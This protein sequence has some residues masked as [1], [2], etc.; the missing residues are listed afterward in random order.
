MAFDIQFTDSAGK[1]YDMSTGTWHV[2]T[3]Q[4]VYIPITSPY[5][6][7]VNF[8]EL[9]GDTFVFF[10]SYGYASGFINMP[11]P[12]AVS[13]AVSGT[14]VTL[15]LDSGISSSPLPVTLYALRKGLTL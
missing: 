5:A 14:S 12:V 4:T 13:M 11:A 15:K 2:H 6:V 8:P 3:A 10:Y 1:V 7:T 9:A